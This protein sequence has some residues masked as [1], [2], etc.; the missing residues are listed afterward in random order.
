MASVFLWADMQDLS[1][2]EYLDK[3]DEQLSSVW[4]LTPPLSSKQSPSLLHLP[5]LPRGDSDNDAKGS[6]F[7]KFISDQEAMLK[8]ATQLGKAGRPNKLVQ[9]KL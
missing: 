6:K 3:P 9:S 4:A 8:S 5:M 1:P 7:A 2:L